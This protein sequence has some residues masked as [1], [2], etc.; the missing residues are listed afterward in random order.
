MRTPADYADI[1]GLPHHVSD[2]HPHMSLADR[3]GQFSPFAALTGYGDAVDETARR[4]TK[5][6]ELAD[7]IPL[8]LL[9]D[10][11]GGLPSE[12]TGE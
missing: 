6:A 11:P 12:M 1:I 4:T 9:E 3:A 5:E 8:D 10:A 7:W 2:R